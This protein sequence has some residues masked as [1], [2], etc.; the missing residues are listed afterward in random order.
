[1]HS[2]NL[3]LLKVIR[4]YNSSIIKVNSCLFLNKILFQEIL[5]PLKFSATYQCGVEYAHNAHNWSDEMKVSASHCTN[6]HKSGSVTVLHITVCTGTWRHIFKI[7]SQGF[8]NLITLEVLHN[9]QHR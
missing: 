5:Y 3:K 7:Y 6:R 4:T 8:C 2:E 1:M 9:A